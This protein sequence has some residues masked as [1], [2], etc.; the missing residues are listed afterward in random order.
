M[1]TP[2]QEKVNAWTVVPNVIYCTYFLLAG[3]WL[4]E[5][6]IEL[7]RLDMMSYLHMQ[8]GDFTQWA[9]EVNASDRFS[10]FNLFGLEGKCISNS[11]FPNLHAVPPLPLLAI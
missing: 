2:L 9:R 3:K 8:E 7:A 1:M 10:L 11:F 6:A 5:Q 4:S